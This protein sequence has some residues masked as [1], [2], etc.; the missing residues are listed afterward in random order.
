VNGRKQEKAKAHVPQ[1]DE[2]G[3]LRVK[4]EVV[5]SPGRSSWIELVQG[6]HRTVKANRMHAMIEKVV[7][8]RVTTMASGPPLH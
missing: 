4:R 1:S 8:P 5:A 6:K 3:P 7:P 2:G